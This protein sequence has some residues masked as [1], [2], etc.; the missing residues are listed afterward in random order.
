MQSVLALSSLITTSSIHMSCYY[1]T[2]HFQLWQ[3]LSG[4]ERL[5][6][7]SLCPLNWRMSYWD[8]G[9]TGEHLAQPLNVEMGKPRPREQSLAPITL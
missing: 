5:T 2:Y 6:F 3:L 8:G 9:D 7:E 1:L 4:P